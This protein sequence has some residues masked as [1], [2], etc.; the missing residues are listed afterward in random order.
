MEIEIVYGYNVPE[1]LK[2]FKRKAVREIENLTSMNVMG[3]KVVAKS[4]YMPE[5]N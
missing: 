3:I 1:T 2:N 5:K 4:I